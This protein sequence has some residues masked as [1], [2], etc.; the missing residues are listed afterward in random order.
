MLNKIIL[1]NCADYEK[2]VV[3]LDTNSIQIV[4]RNNIGKSTLIGVLNFLYVPRQSDWNFAFTPKE[5]LRFYFKNQ[6]KNYI[7]YEIYKNGYFCILVRRQESKLVYYKIDS[8]YSEIESVLFQNKDENKVLSD[9]EHIV[10]SLVASIKKLDDKEYRALLYGESRREKS[11]LW[12][13]KDVKHSTFSRIYKY[14]LNPSLINNDIFKESLL[15]ADSK[16]NSSVAFAHDNNT[17]IVNMQKK[18]KEIERIQKIEQRFSEFKDLYYKLKGK[19]EQYTIKLDMFAYIHKK[20]IEKIYRDSGELT[21]KINSLESN[22]LAPLYDHKESIKKRIIETEND[23]KHYAEDVRR[24]Q[25]EL[26]TINQLEPIE[27]LRM[28]QDSLQND[29]DNQKYMLSMIQKE[30]YTLDG[31]NSRLSKCKNEINTLQNQISNFENLLIHHICSNPE[32]AKVLNALVS[33]SVLKLDKSTILQKITSLDESVLSLFDGKITIEEIPHK[34]PI[35]IEALRTQVLDRESEYKTLESIKDNIQERESR[36]KELAKNQSVLERVKRDIEAIESIPRREAEI[37]ELQELID[38]C[39]AI[40][41][42]QN[43]EKQKKEVLINDAINQ[44]AQLQEQLNQNN[45]KHQRLNGY[46][47]QLKDDLEEPSGKVFDTEQDIDTLF[48]E[49]KGLQKNIQNLE[50]EEKEEFEHLKQSLYKEHANQE[51]FIREV[52]EDLESLQSKIVAVDNLV[53]SITNDT[54]KPTANL[55]TELEHFEASITKLNTQFKK[56]KISN[57]KTIEIKIQRNK[58]V[59]DDLSAI[60]RI[61][62]NNLFSFDAHN[63]QIDILK[64]YISGA[65][66]IKLFDLFDVFFIVDGKE[67]NLKHQIESNGTDIMLKSSLFMLIVSNMIMQDENNKLVIYLDEL[68]AVDDENVKG[69]IQRCVENNFLP[70]FASPDKKAHIEKYYDLLR[71]PQNGK[72]IVD[73]KR[74]IYAT[75]RI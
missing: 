66:E 35:S 17:K 70:I 32:D 75:D 74:A 2:A 24:K 25:G 14:L 41:Q 51:D 20:E 6:D 60:A 57:L 1:L 61:D 16:E 34:E 58:R 73:E 52:E 45:N 54:S 5:T 39:S 33:D 67:R 4:G 9:F 15:I 42:E 49:I 47:E 12:L 71:L 11:V 23:V 21:T 48:T 37:K 7:L 29:I 13:Q 56:Y 8:S 43:I 72:I 31:V 22:T 38:S 50:K 69:F 44:K 36:E 53:E 46:Y 55:L 30:G 64:A 65:K 62:K 68:S 28:S 27:L 19:R 63:N 18:L 26:Q 10:G 59:V 3:S 40:I